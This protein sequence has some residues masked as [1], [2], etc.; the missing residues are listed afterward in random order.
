M[1]SL[2][3]DEHLVRARTF[4]ES[5]HSLLCRIPLII[6][7]NKNLPKGEK[8][9]VPTALD[10]YDASTFYDLAVMPQLELTRVL[11]NE[12][13]FLSWIDNLLIVAEAWESHVGHRKSMGSDRL[14]GMIAFREK[15]QENL[16]DY[17]ETFK[18]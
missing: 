1:P 5:I 18:P 9:E 6:A 4:V 10:A 3:S 17:R 11:E 2:L 7:A 12:K 15:V 14:Q 8:L 13:I 16:K